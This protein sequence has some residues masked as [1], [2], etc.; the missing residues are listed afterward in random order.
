ML[1]ANWPQQWEISHP[2]NLDTIQTNSFALK[3][4]PFLSSFCLWE[5]YDKLLQLKLTAL[6]LLGRIHV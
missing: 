4:T 2:T 3:T 1:P 5:E 6:V